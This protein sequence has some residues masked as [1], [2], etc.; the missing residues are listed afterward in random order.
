MK[1][2]IIID[3]NLKR[4]IEIGSSFLGAILPKDKIKIYAYIDGGFCPPKITN[5]KI[6][7]WD[8][9]KKRNIDNSFL[10]TLR[11]IKN[12]F[13][14]DI[15]H[16]GTSESG[17]KNIS[18]KLCFTGGNPSEVIPEKIQTN[19]GEL[20]IT[21]PIKEG[22]INQIEASQILSFAHGKSEKIPAFIHDVH[23]ENAFKNYYQNLS[24][25]NLKH[26]ES[27]VLNTLFETHLKGFKNILMIWYRGVWC[28]EGEKKENLNRKNNNI[29]RKKI[30]DQIF[31]SSF[32]LISDL[33]GFKEYIK[34]S[35]KAIQS[36]D[37]VIVN[38][39][40]REQTKPFQ[41]FKGLNIV[42]T[43]RKKGVRAPIILLSATGNVIT[44]EAKLK[45]I[46]FIGAKDHSGI[47]NTSGI[48]L[49]RLPNISEWSDKGS[50]RALL[51]EIEITDNFTTISNFTLRDI[52]Y[53]ILEN[54][55][56]YHE[57]WHDEIQSKFPDDSDNKNEEK[58][59]VIFEKVE[60]RFPERY[61]DKL[62]DI[63]T[64]KQQLVN[65]YSNKR[66]IGSTTDLEFIKHQLKGV[67]NFKSTDEEKEYDIQTPNWNILC[68]EDDE[69]D[70]E[71]IS[72]L[73]KFYNIKHKIVNS[74][75]KVFD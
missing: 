20:L 23:L 17:V 50:S 68:V 9:D 10:L 32:K 25:V 72:N 12:H 64:L 56:R 2:I 8:P 53:N 21:R 43:L 18:C 71:R 66:F 14:Y 30:K 73:F 67:M 60:N 29:L 63:D 58:I 47:L 27:G 6:D 38:T 54:T 11:H 57:I 39:E 62:F 35:T 45:P 52:N 31:E 5:G 75:K 48:Y 16:E 22:E 36:H 33:D 7:S 65:K 44:R 13:N 49:F 34:D 15:L 28:Q 3:S 59:S 37:L 46:S 26:K 4:S 61:A 41:L 40:S 24:R 19:K 42:E 69:N 55:G 1:N 51:P 74:P 70:K